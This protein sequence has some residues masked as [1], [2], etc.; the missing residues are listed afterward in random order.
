MKFKVNAHNMRGYLQ[1]EV[2][3]SYTKA[4]DWAIECKNSNQYKVITILEYDVIN[5]DYFLCRIIK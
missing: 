3:S 5:K 1:E 4:L 2:F